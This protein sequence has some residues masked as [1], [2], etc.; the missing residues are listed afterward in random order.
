VEGRAR[1]GGESKRREVKAGASSKSPLPKSEC[2]DNGGSGRGFGLT[3]MC[4]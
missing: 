4:T 3:V 2:D 1:R